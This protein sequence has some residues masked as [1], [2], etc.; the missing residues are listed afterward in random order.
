MNNPLK[1]LLTKAKPKKS[2]KSEKSEPNAFQLSITPDLDVRPDYALVNGVYH[3]VIKAIGYPRKVEDGWLEA[4]LAVSEPYDISLHMHPA[5]INSTLVMLHNQIVKQTADLISSTS[6]GT[7]NPSLEIKKN[8]TTKVYEALYKG[9]EKL[10]QM[11]LYIDNQASNPQELDLLT[12]K[13]KANLNSILIMP[14]TVD[15]RMAE[16]IKSM[17]PQA[18]DA[19]GTRREFLSSSLCATFPFLYPVDSRKKG[20]FFAHEKKT[21]NPLFID[22][23]AMSNKHFFVLG[24]SGSGKSFTSKFLIMQHLLAQKTKVYILDP[25][26]EYRALA[27]ELGGE[28]ITLSKDSPTVINLFDLAGQ[29]YSTK[30]LSLI[31]VFDIITGGLTESQKGVLNEALTRVYEKKGIYGEE[32]RTWGRK[33]PT[34]SDLKS[35]LV[36]MLIVAQKRAPNDRSVEEKSIEALVNRVKMYSKKG[37]FAFLDAQTNVNLNNEFINFDLAEL[38]VH[39]KQLMMFAVLE[40]ISL[41]IK[42]DNKPKVVLIDEG[43]NL[44]RSKEAEQ[45][46]LEFIKTSRK[47]NA[48]IGFITQEIEDL[49]RSDGGKS[50][51]NTTSTK[52]LLRQNASNLQLIAENLALNT[53]EKNFL[54]GAAKGEGLLITE[55]GRYTF[56]INTPPKIYDLITTNPNDKKNEDQDEAGGGASRPATHKPAK[57]KKPEIDLTRGFYLNNPLREEERNT[58]MAAGFKFFKGR[59]TPSDGTAYYYVKTQSNE[60]PDHALVT[61]YIAD[62]IR[63]RGGK[64]TVNATVDADVTFERK[65]KKTC[66]EVE[67]GTSLKSLGEDYIQNKIQK[68][69][70]T[71]DKVIIIVTRRELRDKYQ[72]ITGAQ[73]ITR[74]E[75][76]GVLDRLF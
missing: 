69:K 71:Y 17:L 29:D 12:E 41:E 26:A 16:G 31:S 57:K 66:F 70:N 59:L 36:G 50:I 72:Q 44:L 64:P 55:H 22:F 74:A 68:R 45:Y 14:K 75:V 58:L 49:L 35:I 60:G 43:W 10:F 2:E 3:R 54:L 47:H 52:I 4:F 73:V 53:K 5:P 21:L 27:K 38:P 20:L 7:P 34:F 56:K 15:Y 51:L 46:I 1:Q 63:K 32:P 6:K 33:P 61:W 42:K 67:T 30:M 13:C 39:V 23:D 65:G 18:N 25:N 62:E 8:D 76:A 28:I 37:F 40:R 48:S 19:I 9:E 24:I 11:S